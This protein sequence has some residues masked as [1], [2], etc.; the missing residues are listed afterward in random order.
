MSADMLLPRTGSTSSDVVTLIAWRVE[1][2]AQ[3][4]V[5]DVVAEVETDKST[6]DVESTVSGTVLALHVKEL[7][8]LSI[9]EPLLQVGA[10]GEVGAPSPVAATPDPPQSPTPAAPAPPWAQPA[11]VPASETPPRP[12]PPSTLTSATAAPGR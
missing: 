11:S 12:E 7:D 9:G 3:I 5:G 8:E 4:E 2:G 1:V 10:T 6:V